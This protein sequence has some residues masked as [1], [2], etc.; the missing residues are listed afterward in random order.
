MHP[1]PIEININRYGT[2]Q[3]TGQTHSLPT[4]FW[5]VG[6]DK[7]HDYV[8]GVIIFQQ[9]WPFMAPKMGLNDVYERV[10]LR[11][12]GDNAYIT[13]PISQEDPLNGEFF[14]ELGP[15]NMRTAH[16]SE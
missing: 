5:N 15:H 4:G 10:K 11:I 14:K 1:A 8:T 16:I 6:I 13:V 7:T 3:N 12:E 2:P 9:L